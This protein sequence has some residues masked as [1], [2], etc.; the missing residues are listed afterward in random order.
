MSI[1]SATLVYTGQGNLRSLRSALMN[2]GVVTKTAETAADIASAETLILP[3]VSSTSAIVNYLSE[4]GQWDAV[5][6]YAQSGRRL[7]G[8]CAGMQILATT[9]TEGGEHSG[10][11]ALTGSVIKIDKHPGLRVPHVGWSPV[12][13]T[14]AHD[15]Q[16][17]PEGD[18]YFTHS[19]SYVS[20]DGQDVVAVTSCEFPVTAAVRHGDCFAVQFHPEKSQELGLAFLDS[21]KRNA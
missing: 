8:I 2:V 21:W 20:H 16:W 6:T 19:Y 9:C 15:S 14:S 11:G 4:N 5:Q 12:E 7:L 3:G 13:R 1:G 17:F 10:L 18:Y